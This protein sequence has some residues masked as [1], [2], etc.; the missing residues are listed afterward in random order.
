MSCFKPGLKSLLWRFL[1]VVWEIVMWKTMNVKP[2][3]YFSCLHAT[4]W[5]FSSSAQS[6]HVSIHTLIILFLNTF[7]IFIL[8]LH[9][10]KWLNAQIKNAQMQ[11]TV[12]LCD[13]SHAM[14]MRISSVKPVLWLVVNLHQVLSDGAAF[15]TPSRRSLTSYA[16]SYS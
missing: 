2:K 7:W 4:M 15:N 1:R 3:V 8:Q 9:I 11:F 10:F 12:G 14:I 6:T 5:L 13:I 16:I